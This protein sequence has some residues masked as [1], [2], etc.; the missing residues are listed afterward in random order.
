MDNGQSKS[1][2]VP[3]DIDK[4]Y[5]VTVPTHGAPACLC[6]NTKDELVELLRGYSGKRMCCYVFKGSRWH[7][8]LPPR[9]LLNSEGEIEAEL[10][11]IAGSS[12]PDMNGMMFEDMEVIDDSDDYFKS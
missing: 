12:V 2:P 10:S 5:V 8:S 11:N 6:F 1:E 4:Y 3:P 7:I 9:K